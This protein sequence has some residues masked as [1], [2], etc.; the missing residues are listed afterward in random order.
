MRNGQLVQ[1]RPIVSEENGIA[2]VR[3]VEFH[4][5]GLSGDH[6]AQV[7]LFLESGNVLRGLVSHPGNGI[8]VVQELLR[9]VGERC[10]WAFA[11]N[12]GLFRASRGVRMV[13]NF[14]HLTFDDS[15]NAI[16]IRAAL[17]FLLVGVF[18][19]SPQPEDDAKN[20]QD[21]EPCNRKPV[22]PIRK[23]F[24]QCPPLPKSAAPANSQ[25]FLRLFFEDFGRTNHRISQ[26][27]NPGNAHFH[28]IASDHWPDPRRRSRRD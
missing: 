24:F 16:E 12:A 1:P 9:A 19:F 15:S 11:K 21:G 17:A 10:C 25:N 8:R 5:G 20:N 26:C 13:N 4:A 22:V 27:A 28:H 2:R 23:K 3:G 6:A 18:R 7:G 14:E